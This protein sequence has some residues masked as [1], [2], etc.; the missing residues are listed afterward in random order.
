M[1][2]RAA[3]TANSPSLEWAISYGP[4]IIAVIVVAILVTLYLFSRLR[5]VHGQQAV[6]IERLGVPQ[7]RPLQQ[8]LR[9]VMPLS[10][11]KARVDLRQK[12]VEHKSDVKTGDDAFI[13]IAWVLRFSVQ[14]TSEAILAYVYKVEEPVNQLVF[15]VENELRQI[16]SGMTL[17]ELYGQ[18]DSIARQ[19]IADQAINALE[20]GLR[21][22]GV[23]I[24]QPLP[25]K[26]VQEAMNNKLAAMAKQQAAVAEAEAERLRRVGMAMAESQSKQLQGE[27]IAKQRMAIA[28]GFK[29]S[30]DLLRE[31]MPEASM[32]DITTLL[33]QANQNDMVTTASSTGKAT[34]IFVPLSMGSIGQITSLLPSDLRAHVAPPELPA[35]NAVNGR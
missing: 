34:V 2:D 13:N 16:I 11:V 10:S 1:N 27:G 30:V 31:G 3:S 20:T 25:P 7:P 18:K 29:E 19:I 23:V 8:G 22:D 5:L 14:N 33:L 4:L 9:F 17:N 32:S 28:R 24:E 15:R 12:Q 35:G 26:A 21:I 6:V